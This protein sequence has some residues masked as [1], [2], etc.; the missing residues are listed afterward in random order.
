M[1]TET[2]INGKIAE[3]MKMATSP[4]INEIWSRKVIIDSWWSNIRTVNF[5]HMYAKQSISKQSRLM[6]V[7]ASKLQHIIF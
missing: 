7:N 4:G 5:W 6:A 3:T 1:V 2:F